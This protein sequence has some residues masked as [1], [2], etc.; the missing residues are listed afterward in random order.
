MNQPSIKDL[1]KAWTWAI[2]C[3]DIPGARAESRME[4]QRLRDLK[5]TWVGKQEND[6]RFA[7][8]NYLAGRIQE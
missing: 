2:E 3:E 6:L 8:D 7:L 1:Q 4:L 5:T